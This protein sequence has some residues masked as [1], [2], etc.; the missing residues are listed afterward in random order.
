M[1]R[2]NCFSQVRPENE[3]G[4]NHLN[5]TVGEI[6]KICFTHVY[7]LKKR[8]TTAKHVLAVWFFL[9]T[10]CLCTE[11][12]VTRVEDTGRISYPTIN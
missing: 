4:V 8:L 1:C 3:E 10:L 9:L 12:I 5:D 2:I 7:A 11:K 6:L